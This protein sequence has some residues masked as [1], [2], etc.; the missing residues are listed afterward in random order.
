MSHP[1]RLFAHSTLILALSIALTLPL[2]AQPAQAGEG[3]QR[4]MK[5][6]ATGTIKSKPDMA[7]IS[8]GIETVA[9]K[10][11]SALDDN[12]EIMERMMKEL[13]ASGINEEDIATSNFSIR[14]RYERIGIS[15]RSDG[16]SGPKIIGYTVNNSLRVTVRD[17]SRLGAILDRLVSLGSNRFS[18]ISFG[19]SDPDRALDKARKQAMEKVI[20]KAKLYAK[21]AGVTLGSII[22]INEQSGQ[23]APPPGVF[24]QKTTMAAAVPI[25]PGQHKTF[26]TVHVTWSLTE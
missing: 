7:S 8:T 15:S 12:N 4:T 5:L 13:H 24:R 14:P 2:T 3:K 6:F 9:V 1:L 23:L 25:A 22:S 21:A 26:V 20:H 10:A 18:G 11:R 19:L 17:L 16:R